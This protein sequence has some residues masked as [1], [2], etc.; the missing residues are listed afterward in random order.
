[1]LLL[2]LL[3]L[4][5]LSKSAAQVSQRLLVASSLLRTGI[6]N[7]ASALET[8]SEICCAGVANAAFTTQ[9][10]C[11]GVAEVGFGTKYVAQ[12]SQMLLLALLEVATPPK[13]TT[14]MPQ[15]VS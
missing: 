5:T 15:M 1:M 12:A 3:Q 11:T 13:S 7:A 6:A 8:Y 14:Q 4:A 2:A 10:R 9:I